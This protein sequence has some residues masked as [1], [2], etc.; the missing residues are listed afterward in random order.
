M[1]DGMTDGRKSKLLYRIL[2]KQ[3]RKKLIKLWFLFSAHCFMMLLFIPSFV[4][5]SSS[6]FTAVE[7]K[8]FIKTIIK[9]HK[10]FPKHCM[11]CYGS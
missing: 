9:A 11:W 3:V 1:T 5:I 7:Q 6:V 2:L 4:K 8:L 10:I